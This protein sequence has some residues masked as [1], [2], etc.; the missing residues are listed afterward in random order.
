V[1]QALAREQGFESWAALKE[2]HDVSALDGA[3]RDALADEFLQHACMFS[4]GPL[5]F[6]QKW[7]RA[8]RI[9]VRHPEIARHSLHTAVICGESEHARRILA[10]DPARVSVKAGPPQWEPLL[11]LCYSRLPNDEAAS[12]SVEMCRLLL[13]AGADPN[14]AFIHPE[15]NIK[16]SAL[17]GVMGRG[18]MGG[19]EHS[20]ADELARLLLDRG[21][22]P[23]ESQGLYNTHFDEG[24]KWLELL[25]S[26]GLD[27]PDRVN[28]SGDPDRP[29]SERIGDYL[30][31][32]AA[33]RGHIA[34]LRV[35]LEHGADP[36]AVSRYD[37][38]TCYQTALLAGRL[39]VASILLEHG[40]RRDPLEG[41]DAFVA[42]CAVCNRTE[43]ERL[44]AGHPEYLEVVQP[45]FG[46]ATQGKL[47]V[48]RLLLELGMD[49]NQPNQHG[50][51]A[52]NNACRDRPMCEL[53][54]AHG[55]DPRGRAFGGTASDWAR[56][57]GDIEM[58]R[59]HA[60]HSRL[61]LDATESGHVELARQLVA[62]NPACIGDKHPWGD[63]VLHALPADP[64][65]ARELIEL[66][67]DLGADP[68]V[69][70]DAGKTPIETLIARGSDDVADLLETEIERRASA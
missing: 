53:L 32:A 43:A 45:L 17:C 3:S 16:F 42:A 31:V 36:N 18:E 54:L 9:V 33:G 66:F 30:V 22:D 27:G 20:H 39:E 25:F 62:E 49:P 64:E 56:S 63:T 44:L 50:N 57:A 12:R 10:Q 46:A 28:W 68:T 8:E 61:I 40:A 26:Y 41:R 6:P 23:N 47:D 14:T 60:E 7:R 4:R 37:G 1:Q 35:L 70:N 48:A 52:L 34:R 67:L 19:P 59:W 15:G 11:Y 24:T 69:T 5:D 65:R 2:H 29:D 13:D 38:K 58:A 21:A 51:R 55:A